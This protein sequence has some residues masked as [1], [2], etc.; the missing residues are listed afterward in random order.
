MN[1]NVVVPP[2]NIEFGKDPGI[3][4]FID[5]VGDKGEEIH[6]L[7]VWLLIYW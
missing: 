6:I 2:S 4:N 3:F 1:V 7:M 5:V